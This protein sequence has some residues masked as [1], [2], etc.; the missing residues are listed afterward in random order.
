MPHHRYKRQVLLPEIG[1]AGQQKLSEA[2]VLCVGA[3]G[4]GAPALLYLAAAGIGRIGIVDLDR[5]E[6]SNL[7]RQILYTMDD[8]G[9]TKA[10]AARRRLARLNPLV[11]IEGIATRLDEGNVASLIRDY[12]I[13]VDGTDN[14]ATKFLLNDAVLMQRKI[15]VYG[16]I[17]GFDGQ[18]S[19]FG[20]PNG[21]CYRCLYPAP[22][23]ASV[24]NCAESGVIGAVAGLVGLT[25]AMQVIQLAVG[26]PSFSPLIGTLWTVDARTLETSLLGLPKNPRCP[27]CSLPAEQITLPSSLL[28]PSNCAGLPLEVTAG[29]ARK[30][31]GQAMFVDV[32]EQEEW[33]IGHIDGAF[34]L[35][36]SSLVAGSAARLSFLPFDR[37]IILYCRSG[38]RSLSALHILKGRGYGRLTN[39]SGGYLSWTDS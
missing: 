17:Q 20:S 18:V 2:S 37:P 38:G 6:E 3:G 4:L 24:Q 16:A 19:V 12:E 21:P 35:P 39:L 32:R 31:M 23:K 15:L 14:F 26:T 29:E 7:Q 28:Q 8:L 33:D 36:L 10:E 30:M 34:H 9:E 25:Q 11:Q 27:V 5:V 1:E 13:I 22:P